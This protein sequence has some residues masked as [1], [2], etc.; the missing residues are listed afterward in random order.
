MAFH[1]LTGVMGSG[2]SYAG[3]EICLQAAKEGAIIHTNLPLNLEWWE[4]RGYRDQ[5]V[6]LPDDMREWVSFET[7]NGKQI[8]KSDI[9]VGGS[10]GRENVMVV[11]EASL[12]FDIDDQMKNR[13][14]NKPIFQLVAL[15]RHVGLDL[16]FLA[17]H[18]QNVDAKLRRM[19]ETRTKCIKTERIPFVGWLAAPM[20]GTFRRVVYMGESYTPMAKT[21]HRFNP[22]VGAAYRTHGMRESISMRVDATRRSK[23]ADDSKKKSIFMLAATAAFLVAA[24]GYCI[25][26]F[27]TYKE[28]L[29]AKAKPKAA[30][31]TTESPA[32]DKGDA[33]KPAPGKVK[34]GWRMIEWDEEDELIFAG[35]SKTSD[36]VTVYTRDGQ[37]LGVGLTYNGEPIQEYVPWGG[38][39]YFKT[40]FGRL[41]AVRPL[42]YSERID[43]P[44][45]TVS[46]VKGTQGVDLVTPAF[47]VVDD[48]IKRLTK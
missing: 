21:W 8:P 7:V 11:D 14:Q 12:L 30:A 25:Y 26:H 36:M 20:F 1:I 2:K 45:V 15:C 4:Q 41:I 29:I 48:N 27:A 18:Q 47:N 39:H 34:A 28:D 6:M 9:L 13:A 46:Q 35:R 5:I 38:W 24:V 17:Q 33:P 43:L 44:P 32:D 37:R 42:R 23:G 16:Y 22:D 3:V 31:S 19:A 40:S 10:E